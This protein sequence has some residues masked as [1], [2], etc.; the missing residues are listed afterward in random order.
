MLMNY[1]Q[2][3]PIAKATE[4]IGER[5]TIL[6]LRELLMGGRRFNELQ[7]GLGDISPALLTARLKSL[8]EQGIIVRRKVH[9][10]RSHEY[11]PSAAC[12]AFL[13]VIVAIGEWGLCWTR[14]Q[15]SERDFDISFLMFYLERSIDPEKLPGDHS[16]IQFQFTDLTEQRNWWLIVDRSSVEVCLTQPARDVDVYFTTT[17]RTMHDVWMGDR[18][19]RDAI[20]AEDLI[21]EGE[22]V[23]TRNVSSWLR[24]SVFAESKRAPV[25]DFTG[26]LAA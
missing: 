13:P 25:P 12:D 1:G 23:L 6:I 7:R 11:Y 24:P 17:V 26:K 9:G 21:I 8:E 3:C 10:L 5:W 18:S 19:Y 20:A 15:L 22:P 2:F 4:V 14:D 16:I